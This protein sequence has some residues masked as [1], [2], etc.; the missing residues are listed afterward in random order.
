MRQ[1]SGWLLTGLFLG[2][3]HQSALAEENWPRFRGP[4]GTGISEQKGLPTSW[5][6]KDYE[7]VVEF[8]GKGH[9]SPCLWGTALFITTGKDDGARTLHCLDALTGEERWSDTITLAPSHLHK[10][11][12]YASGTPATDGERVYVGFGDDDHIVVAAYTFEGKKVWSR[13]LGRFES[14]HGFGLSPIVYE[15]KLIVPNDQKGPSFIQALDVMT[16]E[17]LWSTPRKFVTTS[18]ATPMILNV[19][20]EDQ[21]I[22]L[23]GATGLAGLDPGT[24]KS[25]WESGE[26]PQRT[27]ASPVFGNGLLIATCG[28]GGRGQYLAAVDP[29]PGQDGNLLAAERKQNLPYVPTPVVQDQYLFLWNDDGIVCCVDMTGDLTQNV[30]RERVGGNFSGSPVIIDGKIYCISEEG[31][32]VVIDAS[33]QFKLHGSSPLGDQSY[34]TPAVANGR[35]YLRGFQRLACLKA[36][37]KVVTVSE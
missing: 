37:S 10:K 21:I 32:V 17:T 12:S 16:G 25:L 35:L 34:A 18:Y 15:G 5:S 6:E 11:N 19:G 29:T 22:T 33:P 36:S 30:W 8:D 27:V 7:W 31:Q 14:Q 13:D 24:G 9:S 26:L 20:G 3:I 1:Y 4:N 28:Q 2:L 23:S